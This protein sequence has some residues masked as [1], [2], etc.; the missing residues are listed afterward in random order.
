MGDFTDKLDHIWLVPVYQ[1]NYHNQ[2]QNLQM[3]GGD[4]HRLLR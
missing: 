4:G 2:Y 1:E 3:F